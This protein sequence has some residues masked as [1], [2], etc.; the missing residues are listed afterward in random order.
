MLT[1]I[2]DHGPL[3]LC[4]SP[5]GFPDGHA[6]LAEHASIVVVGTVGLPVASLE[7]VITSKRATGRPKDVVA[8]PIPRGAFAGS[9]EAI[10]WSALADAERSSGRAGGAAGRETS[11]SDAGRCETSQGQHGAKA[12]APQTIRAGMPLNAWCMGISGESLEPP[13]RGG[14][15]GSNPVGATTSDSRA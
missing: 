6:T 8:L 14:N 4:F 7:D 12:V 2:T 11:A 3:D 5:A 9:I 13:S 15:A 10:P 1:L